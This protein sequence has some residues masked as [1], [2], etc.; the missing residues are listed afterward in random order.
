MFKKG[1]FPELVEV[2]L[3][4]HPEI[5]GMQGV[6]EKELLHCELLHALD[7]GGWLDRL[8]FQGGSAL[9]L[10]YGASRLSEDLVFSA[11]PRFSIESMADLSACL[12]KVLSGRGIGMEVESPKAKTSH[13]TSGTGV[14]TWRIVCEVLPLNNGIPKQRINLDIDNAPTYAGGPGAITHN[15]GVVPESRM[16]VLAQSRE[17]ILARKIAT[18]AISVATRSCPRFR[19]IWDMN[20]LMGNGTA[21]RD[22][23]VSAKMNDYCVEQSWLETVAASVRDIIYSAE[24][25]KEMRRLLPPKI[26]VQTLDKPYYLEF[27]TNETERLFRKHSSCVSEPLNLDRSALN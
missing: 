18:F 8:T 6:V 4:H 16:L 12:R 26:S 27:L 14:C 5:A 19:D 17:E 23:L 21:I 9:R 15:Y 10:C 20:W 1:E 2:A 7:R 13:T 25:S 24:F 22:D 3:K 11:A